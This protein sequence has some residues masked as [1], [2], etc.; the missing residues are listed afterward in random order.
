[1]LL[2]VFERPRHYKGVEGIDL[3]V[4]RLLPVIKEDNGGVS[5]VTSFW[6]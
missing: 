3:L 1:M 5:E 6:V 4:V 2:D